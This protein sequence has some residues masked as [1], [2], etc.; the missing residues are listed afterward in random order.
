VIF[1]ELKNNVDSVINNLDKIIVEAMVAEK[2]AI[3]D[4]N[5]SNLEKGINTEGNNVGEYESPEY[6]QL[7]KSMGSKSPLGIV[8]TKLTGDFHE[9]FYAEPYYG[10]S[11]ETSGLF[12][13]SKDEKSDDLDR[14]YG[15]LFGLTPD[16][17]DELEDLI[18][19]HIQKSIIDGITKG[20]NR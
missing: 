18:V 5:V 2:E 9:G 19:P 1:A 8:D 10:S 6:A 14:K 13:N 15:N 4:L 16:N 11:P 17:N 7:K 20:I 3:I 12:I